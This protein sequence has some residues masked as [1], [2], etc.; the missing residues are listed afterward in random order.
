[1]DKRVQITITG[2]VQGVFFRHYTEKKAIE[3]G[4]VGYVM[5]QRNGTVFVDVQGDTE[6]LKTMTDW[7]HE[8]SP[9][10][11]VE[12]VTTETAELDVHFNR[13]EIKR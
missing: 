3:L 9:I 7:C 2:R 11:H 4:L 10:S 5:N 12:E 8:G 1:M 13:F 6:S